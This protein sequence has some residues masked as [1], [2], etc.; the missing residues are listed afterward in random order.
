MARSKA[1]RAVHE[2]ALERA[3]RRARERDAAVQAREPLVT[4]E[5]LAHG[6]Y[7]E[8]WTELEGKRTRVLLNRGGSTIQRWLNAPTCTILGDGERAAI[9]YCQSL[10]HRIDHK[11]MSLIRVD[12]GRTDGLAEHEALAELAGL[13]AR[14][15]GRYW[16]LFE[17]ICRWEQPA[18]DRQAKLAVGFVASL[19]AMWR[20]F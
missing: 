8:A 13:R 17:N 5:T 9:R 4:P 20:G 2:S 12:N 15:P 18:P 3:S 10:W 11:G 19:I 16:D 1:A 14:L 7:H 6:D